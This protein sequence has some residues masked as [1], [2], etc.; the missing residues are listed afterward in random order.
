MPRDGSGNYSLPVGNPV[1]SGTVIES[2]W[3]NDT[4]TDVGTALTGSLPTNGEKPM[5]APLKLADGTAS[6]PSLT[7]NSQA[8]TGLYWPGTG[9]L[10][11]TQAG[12]ETMRLKSN[13]NVMIGTTT[14]AGF[15][16]DVNG[17][18]RVVGAS[19]LAALTATTGS[20]SS[21]LEASAASGQ[22]LIRSVSADATGSGRVQISANGSNNSQFSQYGTSAVGT[23]IT[24]VPLAG[25][26]ALFSPAV[27]TGLIIG[28]LA[29]APLYFAT[30]AVERMRIDS[31]GNIGIG[32]APSFRFHVSGT[33]AEVARFNS[34]GDTFVS[35]GRSGT[36][37]GY[38]QTHSSAGLLLV[39][40]ENLPL[41]LYTNN[42]Q[43]L[44]ISAT[45]D[46][47]YAGNVVQTNSVAGAVAHTIQNTSAANN[48]FSRLAVAANSTSL[49]FD[50][51]SSTF[52]GYPDQSWIYN[53]GNA[54]LILG[55]NNL[56][57][58]RITGTGDVGI[59]ATPS[60]RLHVNAGSTSEVARFDT[61]GDTYLS[62][63]R[64]GTRR[65]YVQSTAGGFLMVQ[66]EN[67]PVAFYTNGGFVGQWGASGG[68]AT[69]GKALHISASLRATGWHDTVGTVGGLAAELGVSSGAAWLIAYNRSN[70]T[71]SQLN[72]QGNDIR[73]QNTGGVVADITAGGV[74]NYGG[75]EVGFRQIPRYATSGGTISDLTG[76]GKCYA[77]TG[78]ITVPASTYSAGD[79]VSIYNDS[80]S[81]ITI[82]QGASLTLRLA[83]T[84]TTGNRTLAARGMCTVWFNNATE[85]IISGSGLS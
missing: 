18:L 27:S 73:F 61:T 24:G 40:E 37:T 56:E 19:T 45:G 53:N 78:G 66:E 41:V 35:V 77:T 16:L 81:A 2:D 55:T 26:T 80:A 5:S 6:A 22:A 10:G 85:A 11:F 68:T 31:S 25:L 34:T 47:T 49:R 30:N 65:Q 63:Y 67:A 13:G 74:F 75:I 23:F 1:A 38:L 3:A 42:L 82:T 51:F 69:A 9:L 21:T 50:Q 36:R 32:T 46:L 62:W 70:A 14:D 12:V 59:G 54:P 8:S 15:K 29:A 60:V 43:R 58:V 28:Q 33:A 79:A 4:L 72:L 17:T 76:R 52:T 84:T 64:G 44:N 83:G 20:F 48:A 57:R 39:Q 7:F 71:Y